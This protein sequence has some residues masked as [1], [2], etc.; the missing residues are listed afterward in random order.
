L[1]HFSDL[2]HGMQYPP[3]MTNIAIENGYF[4]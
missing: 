3:V 4:P 2:I 1:C